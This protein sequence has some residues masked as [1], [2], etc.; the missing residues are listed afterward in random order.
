AAVLAGP[1]TGVDDPGAAP[2]QLATELADPLPAGPGVFVASRPTTFA[3][4]EYAQ[5]VAGARPD[6]VVVSPISAATNDVIVANALRTGRIAGA[7]LFAFGRLDPR[8]AYPR[9]RGF[10]LLGREP[11]KLAP[12]RPPARYA[13]ALGQSEAILLA[14]ALARYEGGFGRLDA[15]AHAAGLTAR[16][17]AADLA[18]LATSRPS[19]PALFGFVPRFDTPTGPWL[20]ELLGDDLAWVAGLD[21]PGVDGE[22]DAAPARRLHAL[23]RKLLTGAITPEDPA[24]AALGPRAV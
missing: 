15:A 12:I 9:G 21:V 6:L 22:V 18:I 4:L 16:F 24:I 8:R 10:E 13:S 3:A 5:L 1:A 20:L 19:R 23:W 17:G 7:D 14:L 2:A 11:D